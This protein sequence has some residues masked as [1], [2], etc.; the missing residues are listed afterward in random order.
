MKNKFWTFIAIC[1]LIAGGYAYLRQHLIVTTT[2]PVPIVVATSTAPAILNT[3][4]Y[5]CGEGKTMHA[6]FSASAV[7]LTLSDGR[8]LALPQVESG[9]GIRYEESTGTTDIIFSSKGDNA[10]LAENASST[11]KDCIA[12][13]VQP[14]IDATVF[15]DQNKTFSFSFPSTSTLSVTGD[16]GGY[17]TSWMV[18]AT[19]SGM[20]LAQVKVPQSYQSG[21]NFADAVFTVGTSADP[22]A[23]ST[24]LTYN[25]SGSIKKNA[26]TSTINGVTYTVMHSSDAGAGNYYDTTSYRIAHNSQCYAIEYTIHYA[27]FKNFPKGTVKEFDEAAL[28]AVLD[29]IAQ[30][31]TFI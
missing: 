18:N 26:A 4:A 1:I 16:G 23:L 27:N 28:T 10:F 17:T 5:S 15:T 8:V 25:P 13:T 9:S 11:Y 20:I 2:T 24:C 29:R 31:F 19:T 22:S 30:S 14:G 6:D 12:G 3:T 21:T 7:G